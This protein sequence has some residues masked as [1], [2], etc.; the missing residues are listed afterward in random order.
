MPSNY[1]YY[2][3]GYSSQ[4]EM[5]AANA[6]I[7]INNTNNQPYS[8]EPVFGSASQREKKAY[9]LEQLQAKLLDPNSKYYKD[10]NDKLK[11]T[12]SAGSSTSSLLAFN[13][14]MGLGTASSATI[15]NEQ[16]KANQSRIIDTATEATKDLY[17]SN[18]GNSINL[19]NT[20]LQD[21]QFTEEM[22]FKKQQL[23]WEKDLYNKRK[24]DSILNNILGLVGGVGSTLL[25][26]GFS[27]MFN[28][29]T[30]ITPSMTGFFR[31][32]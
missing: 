4:E 14:G 17:L 30:K 12:L 1:D 18:V 32:K 16:N 5:D 11:R 28:S 2:L 23:Q 9:N 8:T 29:S 15:A 21:E 10:Y 13:K 19:G 3:S 25:T 20:L 24:S 26:G 7:N 31:M 27:N 6:G 22:N